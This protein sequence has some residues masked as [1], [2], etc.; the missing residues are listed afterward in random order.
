MKL[1]YITLSLCIVS[2]LSFPQDGE[3]M[4]PSDEQ[5]ETSEEDDVPPGEDDVP[6]GDEFEQSEE[7][8]PDYEEEFQPKDECSKDDHCDVYGYCGHSYWIGR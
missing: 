4:K 3:P 7:V 8:A 2:A 6:P 1:F 5:I